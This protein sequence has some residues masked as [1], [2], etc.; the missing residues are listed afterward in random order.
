MSGTSTRVI[1]ALCAALVVVA[2]GLWGGTPGLL[3]T[4]VFAVVMSTREFARMIFPRY[5]MPAL[6]T[7]LYWLTSLVFFGLAT[8]PTLAPALPFALAVI[9]FLTGAIWLARDRVANDDLLPALAL[10]VL[11]MIYCALFPLY[12]ARVILGPRG[13]GWFGFLLLLVFAG[14]TFA[15]FTGRIWG[16]RK[17][18]PAISPGKT[19]EGSLGGLVGSGLAGTALLGI[20]DYGVP[21]WQTLAFS[22]TCGFVAQ[23][24]DLFLSL[25]KRVSGVKDSGRIMPG[26]GGLLD[27]L[28]GI[29]I[30][31]PLV[32]A[33]SI[34][35]V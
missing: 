35:V 29:F 17:F 21:W 27:R 18:M 34:A 10:G 7:H 3:G 13:A 31:C 26:H 33:F 2:L 8:R 28:D 24:G 6:I 5:K 11:G 15:Y 4:V 32:Y 1:S 25:V 23:S 12:A 22:V 20:L 16:R 19:W 14:D 9:A 30:A